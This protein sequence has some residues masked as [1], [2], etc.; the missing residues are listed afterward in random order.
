MIGCR[1]EERKKRGERREESGEIKEEKIQCTTSNEL[2]A[3]QMIDWTGLNWHAPAAV[4]GGISQLMTPLIY[5]KS[6][7]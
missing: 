2:S 1:E 4:R 5:A 6:A 3:M 7:S